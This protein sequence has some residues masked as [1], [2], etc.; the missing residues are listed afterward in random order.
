MG[1]SASGIWPQVSCAGGAWGRRRR[2]DDPGRR[3]PVL[4]PIL[5]VWGSAGQVAVSRYISV[6]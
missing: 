5:F 4:Y 1:V 2:D 6:G 3:G